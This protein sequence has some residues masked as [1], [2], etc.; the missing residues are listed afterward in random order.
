MDSKLAKP[1]AR[2]LFFG[3]IALVA[4][5]GFSIGSTPAWAYTYSNSGTLTYEKDGN[6]VTKNY[7]DPEELLDDADDAD[8]DVTIDMNGDWNTED[9]RLVVPSGRHYTLNMHGHVLD[10]HLAATDEDDIWYGK[11]KG[12]VICLRKNATLTVNGGN[13]KEQKTAHLGTWVRSLF[14][15]FD[16]DRGPQYE[17]GAIITGG[18]GVGAGGILLDGNYSTLEL[19][20]VTV[21]GNV[22]DTS[23]FATGYNITGDGGG[24][25]LQGTESKLIMNNS[26]ISQNHS[27][28]D[29]AGV[30]VTGR[31][32]SISMKNG[33]LINSNRSAGDGGGVA[34]SG[35]GAE[36]TLESDCYANRCLI[37]N[38]TAEDDGGGVYIN[39]SKTKILIDGADSQISSND[40]D[41]NGGGVFV[42][43]SSST[44]TINQGKIDGNRADDGGG[45]YHNAS[46][47]YIYLNNGGAISGN[48]AEDGNG[49]G[50]YSYY[51]GTEINLNNGSISGNTSEGD[52]GGLYLNDCT[53]VHLTNDSKIEGNEAK[54]QY[55]SGYTT[56]S[57][58]GGG[59]YV[60]DDDTTITLDNSRISKNSV[61]YGSG[62]GIYH[63][64]KNGTVELK[65][66]STIS[67]NTVS[68]DGGGVYNCYNG[69]TYT[70][71]ESTIENNTAA[72]DGGGIYLNDVATL[73]VKSNSAIK[74]NKAT[75]GGGVYIDDDGCSIAL[76]NSQIIGNTASANGAGV[77]NNDSSTEISLDGT[78]GINSNTAEG[79]GGGLYSLNQ[80]SLASSDQSGF[81]WNSAADGAG[82]WF[83]E[84]L[85]LNG[86]TVSQN[87]ASGNGGGIYCNETESSNPFKLCGKMTVSGNTA[88]TNDANSNIYLKG[89]K[90]LV[91]GVNSEALAADSEIGVS[92]E[93]FSEGEHLISDNGNIV[94]TLGEH[95][96]DVFSADDPLCSILLKDNKLYLAGLPVE[97]S[98]TCYGASDEPIRSEN[99]AYGTT[100]ELK[101]QDYQDSGLDPDWWTVSSSDGSTRLYPENGSASFSMPEY[102]TTVR[103]HYPDSKTLTLEYGSGKTGTLKYIAGSEVKLTTADYVNDEGEDPTWWELKTSD[104]VTKIYSSNSTVL[105]M[106]IED[107]TLTA[108]YPEALSSLN[109]TLGES[110]SW[111]T[112]SSAETSGN[113]G[114]YLNNAPI[115]KLQMEDVAGNTIEPS[116]EWIEY[117]TGT[118]KQE[119]TEVTD[120]SGNVTQKQV[121]YLVRVENFLTYYYG[122]KLTGD[123]SSVGTTVKIAPSSLGIPA[124]SNA[125]TSF[126]VS[127]SGS[128]NVD[129]IVRFTATYQRPDAGLPTVK[130]DGRDINDPKTQVTSVGQ[131]VESG[132]SLTIEAPSVSGWEFVEWENLPQNAS[133]DKSNH[134]VT[135]PAVTSDI[136]LKAKY[137]PVV[138]KL[139][140]EVAAP[141]IGGKFP[142]ELASASITAG[143]TINSDGSRTDKDQSVINDANDEV[144]FT[145]E[146]ADKAKAGN[147]V[148]GDTTYKGSICMKLPGSGWQFTWDD[149]VV[150]T[151][152]GV[153]A[154]SVEISKADGTITVTWLVKTGPDKRYDGVTTDLSDVS[155]S[156]ASDCEAYLP[157]TISYKLKD[158][159]SCSAEAT[160]DTSVIDGVIASDSF[161][162][163][164]SFEDNYGKKQ[165]VSRT[166]KLPK[167]G[168][169]KPKLNSSSEEAQLV[170]LSA[171]SSWDNAT[172]LQIFYAIAEPGADEPA[173][174]DYIE[175]SNSES[176]TEPQPISITKSCT[177]YTYALVDNRKTEVAQYS[178]SIGTERKLSFAGDEDKSSFLVNGKK[179]STAKSGDVVT[180][181]AGEAPDGL[182][183]DCWK[184]I[185][186]GIELKDPNSA[187]TSF[188][189]GDGDGEI[190]LEAVY[191]QKEYTVSFN[192]S[193]GSAVDSQTVAE[194]D[195][196]SEPA[197]PTREGY[198]FIGWRLND[199][200]YNFEI[201][202]KRDI[203]LTAMW[204]KIS[205]SIADAQVELSKTSFTYNGKTQKPSVKSV[206]L[207]GKTLQDGKDYTVQTEA[208]KKVGTYHVTIRANGGSCT[209]KTTV[210]YTINPKKLSKFKVTKAKKSFKAK[211]KKNKTERS[212][213]QIRYSLKKSMKNAKTLKVKDSAAKAKKVKKLKSK[214]KYYVQ[215][216][217]Y[218]IVDGKTYYSDWSKKK[219]VK[220]K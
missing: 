192:S 82:I 161:T 107:A 74:A 130:I 208:G 135:L 190:E 22:S 157:S 177:L 6:T 202:I 49:G 152:N 4:I 143:T 203:T 212:G 8:V 7:T 155:I 28:R 218:K 115:T 193:G 182:Q 136:E 112:L 54:I 58:D 165:A 187:K 194:G 69:T 139:K 96:K 151:V 137:Q 11:S 67:E 2:A 1:S 64:A 88:G 81:R 213:V 100:V 214:K 173:D 99:L 47:G 105:T 19:N 60:N 217:A 113:Y 185:S 76:T 89:T 180:V 163:T 128:T 34:M 209:G 63:N 50:V 204:S 71:S 215:A 149:S 160:W 109:L 114:E 154:N 29:G 120:G 196:A 53:E 68:E 106:P 147:A 37:F 123:A 17:W 199:N 21:A 12:D 93:G 200:K 179:A 146:K 119:V 39:Q 206:I 207:S 198:V 108:R 162:V 73:N 138:S 78:S 44:I 175:Y 121:K 43:A 48:S 167:I 70:L 72:N 125:T 26:D 134:A 181:V 210:S 166:F 31:Y 197:D 3:L 205:D 103:A 164:G 9:V 77:Y 201:K 132:E 148:E 61:Q 126:E 118:T 156:Q 98:L 5:L 111:E 159:E 15:K 150:A 140:L 220:T 168:A 65:N 95:V 33:S 90:H 45:V 189:L 97:H 127:K 42:D 25:T 158:G 219:L 144:S 55:P 57:C 141:T 211:W 59:I 14:W 195:C 129:L 24:V 176:S 186:G 188:V 62:G 41:D 16:P 83:E 92:V 80:L 10:R 84:T 38:N 46:G 183:F 75:N 32:C 124:I 133:E 110:N 116:A 30:A 191:K 102:D 66:H 91:S 153:A 216:R 94:K 174:S 85:T 23:F 104:G 52:G 51:N 172:K 171:N 40:A 145:W 56:P 18:A 36:I 184:V 122:I 35:I 87:K 169:P 131:S 142:S 170:E 178:Y 117:D 13:E 86:L 79:N 27:E 101:T 20:D